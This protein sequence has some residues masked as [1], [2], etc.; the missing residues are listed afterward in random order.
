MNVI[1]GLLLAFVLA[2]LGQIMSVYMGEEMMGMPKSPIS[3][4]MTAIIL[5]IIVR[6]VYDLPGWFESSHITPR[7]SGPRKTRS[8]LLIRLHAI[9]M[10]LAGEACC[11][12]N[13]TSNFIM[14]FSARE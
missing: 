2:F 9:V 11:G 1:P 13:A 5:G 7:I 10:H 4:I 8:G 6:N 3:P 14:L 12:K